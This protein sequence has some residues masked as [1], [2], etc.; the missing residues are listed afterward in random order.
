MHNGSEDDNLRVKVADRLSGTPDRNLIVRWRGR[1]DVIYKELRGLAKQRQ[2]MATTLQILNGNR[3]FI[4]HPGRILMDAA[5]EWYG[6]SIALAYRRQNDRNPES[7][8]LRVVVEEMRARPGAY[9]LENL[10]K[11]N[12]GPDDIIEQYMMRS[13][14]DATGALDLELVEKDLTMLD[15]EGQRVGRFASKHL[16]HT[17]FKSSRKPIKVVYDDFERAAETCDAIAR[18]WRTALIGQPPARG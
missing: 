1:I 8:S 10:R 17:D 6:K 2:M 11:E 16:A 9:C 18:R 5:R 14:V 3:R 13:V 4:E 7:A 12:P 15:A